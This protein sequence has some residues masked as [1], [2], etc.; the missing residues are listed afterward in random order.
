MYRTCTGY[1]YL[2]PL[3]GA[4]EGNIETR[5]S[6]YVAENLAGDL[7]VMALCS[8]FHLSHSEIYSIFKR[9][10]SRAPAEHVK[11]CRLNE[12]CHLLEHTRMPVNKI[13]AAIGV[14]DYNYFSKIFKK[15][16]SVS[17]REFRASKNAN[18]N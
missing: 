2:K 14:P 10:F 8:A 12:A 13:A 15:E 7:S 16:F 3:M 6:S 4:I 18:Q 1:E 9:C 5:I 11:R 17:P